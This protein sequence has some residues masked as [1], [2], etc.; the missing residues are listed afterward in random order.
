MAFHIL[1]ISGSLR[2][3]SYNTAALRAVG[4]L[5]PE[6]TTFEIA[7]IGDL[8]FYNEDLRINGS[9]PPEAQRLR[10]Q[11]AKADALVFAVPEYNYSLPAVLK[12]AVDWASR[13]PNQ[14][15]DWK[16]FGMVGAAT[17]LLGT[18]RAQLA[19]RHMMV[20]VNAYP[21]NVPQV[22]IAGAA[23][24][25]DAEGKLIDQPARDLIAQHVQALVKLA[26][27]LKA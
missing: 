20:G 8:P 23:Q 7:E 10:A 11:I 3:A 12:N 18:V 26:H 6:G 19:L 17:G 2:K 9:F 5:L 22:M 13:A 24:K 4:E 14:P 21:V 16:A 27:K 25:F 1:G 15:F